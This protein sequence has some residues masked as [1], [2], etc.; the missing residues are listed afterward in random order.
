MATRAELAGRIEATQ[1][2][3]QELV[4]E[5]DHIDALLRIFD[6]DIDLSDIRPKLIPAAH[7]AFG[8]K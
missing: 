8:A 4:M 7:R 6:P 3:L 2:T 1:H 5:L